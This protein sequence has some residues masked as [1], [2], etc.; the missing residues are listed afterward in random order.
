MLSLR[1]AIAANP[2]V[3]TA[4]HL[5]IAIQEVR[6]T[7]LSPTSSPRGGGGSWLG[8]YP[9]L[10]RLT[11]I[12]PQARGWGASHSEPPLAGAYRLDI[13]PVTSMD[14]GVELQLSEKSLT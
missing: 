6:I 4:H 5:A 13:Q 14:G 10:R 2:L 7:C 12:R 1:R 9:Y 3:G 8:V 11:D